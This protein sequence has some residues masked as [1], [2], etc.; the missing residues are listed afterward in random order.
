MTKTAI[1]E[2][3]KTLEEIFENDK[4][5]S[6]INW[7]YFLQREHKQ[8]VDARIDGLYQGI[9]TELPKLSNEEYFRNNYIY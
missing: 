9:F 5:L 4:N 6:N 8:I 3:K 1:A 2:L 7:D